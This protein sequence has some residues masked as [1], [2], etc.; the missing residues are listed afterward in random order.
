[1]ISS[2]FIILERIYVPLDIVI[3]EKVL[4][5]PISESFNI[6]GVDYIKASKKLAEHGILIGDAKTIEEICRKN[7]VSPPDL[8]ELIFE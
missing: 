3:I 6:L 8:I 1:M 2:G 5:A 4:S 7:Q